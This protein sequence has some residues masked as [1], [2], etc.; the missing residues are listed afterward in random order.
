[1]N[2]GLAALVKHGFIRESTTLAKSLNAAF[3][4]FNMDGSFTPLSATFRD[5]IHYSIQIIVQAMRKVLTADLMQNCFE[6]TGHHVYNVSSDATIDYDMMMSKTR[7]LMQHLT[8]DD[9]TNLKDAL[10]QCAEQFRQ[11][12]IAL[13]HDSFVLIG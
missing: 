7:Y 2:I 13:F 6:G 1:M 12:G 4:Q 11:E 8:A 10:P 3:A 9:Y 5:K